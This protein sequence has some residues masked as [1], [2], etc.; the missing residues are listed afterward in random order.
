MAAIPPSLVSFDY[1]ERGQSFGYECTRHFGELDGELDDSRP[2]TSLR[3]HVAILDSR[4]PS[5]IDSAVAFSFPRC[6]VSQTEWTP[7][8]ALRFMRAQ[9]LEFSHHLGDLECTDILAHFWDLA[10]FMVIPGTSGATERHI[11]MHMIVESRMTPCYVYVHE[12]EVSTDLASEYA[13]ATWSC[14]RFALRE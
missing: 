4:G 3:I 13:T 8:A 12:D 5:A 2:P 1:H 10:R 9:I 14:L 11:V 7:A 6:G